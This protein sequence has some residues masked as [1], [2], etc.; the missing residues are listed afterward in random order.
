MSMCA[1]DALC[2]GVLSEAF[3]DLYFHPPDR[4]HWLEF[5]PTRL[6]ICVLRL[7]SLCRL[8]R[9]SAV[10]IHVMHMCIHMAMHTSVTTTLATHAPDVADYLH[11]SAKERWEGQ[12][13]FYYC[14]YGA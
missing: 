6:R 9:I 2:G 1:C 11:A 7:R 8:G 5:G 12:K 13:Q 10:A 4:P 14:H 3:L